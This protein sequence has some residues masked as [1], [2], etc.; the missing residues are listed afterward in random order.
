M[1]LF[2]IFFVL[3]EFT[4]YAANDMIMPGMIQVVRYFNVSEY[5]VTSALSYYLL[6]NCIF[7]LVVGFFAEKFGKRRIIIYGNFFFILFTLLI[8]FSHTIHQFIIWRFLQGGGL[9]IIP[10]GYALIHE[11]FNDKAAIKLQ[12]L[13]SNVSIL[14][15]LLGPLFGSLIISFFSWQHI[16]Y[17]TTVCALMSLLG[18]YLFAP[19][20]NM[21]KSELNVSQV[22]KQ[23]LL[24]LRNKEFFLGMMSSTLLVMPLLIW[25]GQAPNLI[26]YKLQ[27]NYTHYAIYQV[28]AI[29]GL[30][31]ASIL[32]QFIVDKFRIY[33]I[34]KFGSFL[35]L[36]GTLT[37]LLGAN[38]IEV[39]A[40]G[41][42]IYTL[43]LCLANGC[44]WRIILT[45]KGYSHGMLAAMLGCLQTLLLFIGITITNMIINYYKFASI[46]FTMCLFTLG[47]FGFLLSL[48]YI[49]AYRTREWR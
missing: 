36:I 40:I 18:L 31:I 33:S 19:K 16:F 24:I 8:I 43:G 22:T 45:I 48:N 38:Y 37:S 21:I 27:L 23:Y 7:L 15:P 32:M 11:K 20:S 4:T 13:M 34:I 35:V 41:I 49:K 1:Y 26:L 5:Y 44:L 28:I 10:M 47:F 42:L 17:V 9:A 29:G 12:A 14:A 2:A 3:Y 6:G 25:I 30:L 46:S 39:I